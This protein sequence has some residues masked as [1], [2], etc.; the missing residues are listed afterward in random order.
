[1]NVIDSVERKDCCGCSACVQICP[2]G[3]LEMKADRH[4]FCFPELTDRSCLDCGLCQRVCPVLEKDGEF[5]EPQEVYA[6]RNLREQV[7]MKSS[8][9]GVFA[10]LA[11]R[12]LDEGGV[13]F[14]ARFDSEWRVVH[15][16]TERA[17]DLPRFMGSKYVQSDI[18]NTYVEAEEYLKKGKLVLFTGTPCQIASLHTFLKKD[19]ENLITMDV[20]C[21]GVPSRRLWREFLDLLEKKYHSKIVAVNFRDKRDFGWHRPQMAYE[22]EDGKSHSFCGDQ[23]FFQMFNTN[24]FLRP[25]CLKCKLISYH[26]PS[27]ISV[28]DYW[29]IER[30]RKDFDDNKGTSMILLNTKKGEA[31]FDNVKSQMEYFETGKEYCWQGRL[32][33]RS[34]IHSDT[35]RFW[36][37]YKKH[38]LKYV[39]VKYTDY[40]ASIKFMRR[41]RN[42]LLRIISRQKV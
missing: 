32:Q 25:S 15:D 37:E 3:C 39:L 40:S 19:Y 26:R 33:G 13:V 1:M 38:G 28:A 23:S 8:S 27:D 10:F 24:L 20:V 2:E 29:G 31:L 35:D 14:A 12:V 34:T 36:K 30:F 17:E 21:H 4:G 5:V 22:Y 6:V 11:G 18:K 7:R 41:V 16:C 9:G 42:K